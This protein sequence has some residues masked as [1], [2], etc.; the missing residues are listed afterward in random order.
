MRPLSLLTMTLLAAGCGP[1][2]VVVPPEVKDPVVTEVAG[3]LEAGP[4]VTQ[5]PVTMAAT[6]VA[7]SFAGGELAVVTADAVMKRSASAGTLAPIPVGSAGETMATGPVHF[8][9]R[10][11]ADSLWVVADNGLFH[12]LDGR[13]LK[14]PLSADLAGMTVTAID[15]YGEGPSEELWLTTSEGV[16]HVKAMQL[17]AVTVEFPK[18]GALG[19]PVLAIGAGAGEA[20]IVAKGQV[21]HVALA[22]K[23]AE[24]VAKDIG[25]LNAWART[26]DGDV[27]L[28]TSAGLYTRTKAGEMKH[29]AIVATDVVGALGT[30]LIAAEGKIARLEGTT[31]KTFGDVTAPRARG[32]QLDAAGDTFALDGSALIKLSTAKPTSFAID[33]KPFFVAHCNTCHVARPTEYPPLDFGKYDVAKS[34]AVTVV[35]RLKAE[36]VAPMPPANTEVL[37]AAEYAVVLKWV[38]GGMQP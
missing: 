29:R 14:S 8:V 38:A 4:A 1:T 30:V 32:L 24:W 36:G 9:W 26:D 16:Q 33:V 10:R 35:K 7:L 18:L 15:G 20:L 12:T 25:T 13:L 2:T 6:P 5:A 11:G 34:Y 23:K 28:A 19:N 22:T 37:S 3:G 27:M 21:F 31:F 17:N